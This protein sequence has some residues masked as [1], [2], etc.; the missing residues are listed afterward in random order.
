MMRVFPIRLFSLAV[1]TV[2]PLMACT[3]REPSPLDQKVQMKPVQMALS[4]GTLPSGT[5]MDVT[6]FTEMGIEPGF[7]G[8]AD[9]RVIPFEKTEPV[10]GEDHPIS[11]P[12]ALP[13][14]SSQ[15]D[16]VA[17]DE[18]VFHTGLLVGS[19]AH[20]YSKDV[21]SL[22]LGTGAALLY[23]RPVMLPTDEGTAAT[24][25]LNGSLLEEG[26]EDLDYRFPASVIHFSPDPIYEGGTYPEAVVLRSIM[27]G[28]VL[29]DPFQIDYYSQ[30]G[31]EKLGT[32]T[33]QWDAESG[34][35]QLRGYYASV[36]NGG[37]LMGGSGRMVLSL[38]QTLYAAL[39]SYESTDGT[40]YGITIGANTV[41]LYNSDGSPLR[42]SQICNGLSDRILGRIEQCDYLELVNGVPVFKDSALTNY[43]KSRG[44]PEGSTMLRYTPS[45]FV[46][47]TVDGVDNMA[48][49]SAF[50]YPPALYYYSNSTLLSSPSDDVYLRYTS[51]AGDWDTILD[52]YRFGRSV[53]RDSKSVAFTS[54]L[55]YAVGMLDVNVRA[56]AAELSDNDGDAE[57]NVVVGETSF[58][59][60]GI[61]VGGQ[62]RQA[63]DFTPD[64]DMQYF[65]YDN[66]LEGI[67]LTTT[68]TP[69]SF[70]T[71]V[72]Q[73][74]AYEDVY[75]CLELQ[76]ESGNSF[77]GLDGKIE[78]G[79]KFYLTGKMTMPDNPSH[80]SAIVQDH[81]TY[82]SCTVSSLQAA[83]VTIPDLGM[84]QFSL[85]VQAQ[86]N[87]EMSAP[88][89]VILD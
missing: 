37:S 32:L 42:V 64:G 51:S 44:L 38:I 85:G 65:V 27:D 9:I 80:T 47:P 82:L 6:E 69:V 73:S 40:Q 61:I 21:V 83:R 36:V 45:G 1:L 26:L 67:Y 62:Y 57:T 30:G 12:E 2:L 79:Q 49:M 54:P 13:G 15:M 70:R 66:L 29:G 11:E 23:G 35:D 75:F 4:L 72:L 50:C 53:S 56:T 48:P 17:Y 16:E 88:I 39:S 22:P 59:V 55:Q 89:T 31:A 33:V 19:H 34:D 74:V 3:E 58:P 14:I 18:G 81:I 78:K 8:L 20:F 86:V 63:Y 71:L 28:I 76:N 5:K 7:R 68:E 77:Y 52:N 10:E 25:H 46:I 24:K 41:Y 60:T 43:P 84:P 87:W